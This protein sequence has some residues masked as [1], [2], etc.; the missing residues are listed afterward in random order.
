MIKNNLV[1]GALI[2]SAGGIITKI[3]GVFYRI[4]LTNLL[5]AEG[6]GI[7][8][9]V[10]PLYTILLTFSSTGVPS[11]ISK[12]IAEGNDRLA[13]LKS[14]I[15]IFVVIGF[16]LSA[17]MAVFSTKIATLQGNE[18]AGIAY[19]LM[20]PSVFFVSIISCF[21]GYYQGLSNMKPTAISQ[22]IE[23]IVKLIFGILACY[24]FAGNKIKA[25]GG[26]TLAVTIS[27]AV[28]LLYF[29]VLS[30]KKNVFI[31]YN[32]VKTNVLIVVKTVIPMAVV[33]LTI[34]L[35]RTIDSFLILNVVGAYTDKATGL[36]GLYS[37]A[38][39]SIIG[40]P[41]SVCYALSVTSI[42]IISSAIKNGEDYTKKISQ[43]VGITIV[44]SCVMAICV[45]LFSGLAVKILYPALSESNKIVTIKM[46]KLSSLSVVFLS[47]MQ[48][49]NA[50]INASGKYKVTIFSGI[51]SGVFKITFSLILLKN[52][53][54]NVFGA[55][56]SDIICY[57]VACFIN[58]SY[59]IYSSKKIS[60]KTA[61]KAKVQN[62]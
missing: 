49:L 35:I 45:Y 40:V 54:V 13:V 18:K 60:G 22:V 21:R 19:F 27:E 29:L 51:V 61:S 26:A 33:T 46:L 62:V 16:I 38:V 1:K 36:Y 20:S 23:Q 7:Y 2:L 58:L 52:P 3:I 10:F 5:G 32:R 12:L 8:Q 28:T 6:I 57:F 44:A 47:I 30:K 25:V 15:K 11:G 14:A 55:I 37:G 59:I 56:L 9:M 53:H 34:P 43:A 17:F 42:P 39:E 31:G 50:C 48:T 4:P 41:V 24:V